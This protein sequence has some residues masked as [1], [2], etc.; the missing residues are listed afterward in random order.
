MRKS[1]RKSQENEEISGNC[2]VLGHIL[3]IYAKKLRK[4]HRKS[5]KKE[6]LGNFDH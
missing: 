4:Y 2:Q 6:I 5:E 3:K 1:L